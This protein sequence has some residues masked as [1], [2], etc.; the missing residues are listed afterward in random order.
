VSA[1]LASGK[2]PTKKLPAKA[3]QSFPE[4]APP[5]GE[6]VGLLPRGHR[7]CGRASS[8]REAADE[9]AAIESDAKLP[10]SCTTRCEEVDL[11]PGATGFVSALLASGKLPTKK[12][13]SKATQSLPEAAPSGVK[14]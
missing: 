6:E 1:L 14:K 2:L 4:A 9:K 3:T 5:G 13:P 8:F 7:V 12:L 11:L 10:G